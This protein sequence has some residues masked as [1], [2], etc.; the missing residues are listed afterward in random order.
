MCFKY[1][2]NVSSQWYSG[3]VV[4]DRSRQE[5]RRMRTH[6]CRS[7]CENECENVAYC[8]ERC[9]MIADR[10]MATA[11]IMS[12]EYA[13]HWPVWIECIMVHNLKSTRWST[14][15]QW[16]CLTAGVTCSFIRRLRISHTAA[17]WTHWSRMI[18]DFAN[19]LELSCCS[20][21]SK[22]RTSVPAERWVPVW[23]IWQSRHSQWMHDD[24][25]F[26]MC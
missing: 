11:R 17:Y 24:V 3:M 2:L 12:E 7:Q 1:F 21:A 25:T 15:N 23:R 20:P 4:E 19:W 10:L 13:G 9:R 6:A 18:T 16:S 14:G 22:E 8:I 26:T 5:N